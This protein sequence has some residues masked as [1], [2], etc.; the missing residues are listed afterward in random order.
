MSSATIFMGVVV[1][2]SDSVLDEARRF[3]L[4]LGVILRE[5][6]LT[7]SGHLLED[8]TLFPENF[9]DQRVIRGLYR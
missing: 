9:V 7:S 2:M 3:S 5:G 8:A 1:G 4:D 6:R